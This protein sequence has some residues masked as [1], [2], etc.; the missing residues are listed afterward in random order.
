MWGISTN[1]E[2]FY[3]EY[4]TKTAALIAAR[5]EYADSQTWVGKLE[6]YHPEP[7]AHNLVEE[8]AER[9][10]EAVGDFAEG[11]PEVNN[12]EI[13]WLQGELEKLVA[14]FLKKTGTEPTFKRV[15]NIEK[16]Q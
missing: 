2:Q 15:Q 6:K 9:A 1:Q 5:N 11:W 8:L 14:R 13:D 16:V 3:G 12:K 7:S 10:Y 4:K